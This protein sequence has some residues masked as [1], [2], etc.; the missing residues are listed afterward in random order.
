ML[1]LP[2]LAA[3]QF[4]LITFVTVLLA[5]A[6]FS[7]AASCIYIVN[8]LLDLSKIEAGEMRLESVPFD[9]AAILEGITV[10]YGSAAQAKS[11]E[12]LTD[13]DPQVPREL[14]GDPLGPLQ[15]SPLTA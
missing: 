1:L 11:I 2:L 14:C 5:I 15:N 8:D 13:I 6:A 9:V 4:G 12:I 3:H 7:A 10:N